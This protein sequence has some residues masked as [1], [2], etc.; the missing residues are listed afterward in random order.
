MARTIE[1]K[2]YSFEELS[3]EAKQV[4]I[5]KFRGDGIDISHC[6]DDAHESVKKFHEMFGSE[7][8]YRSWLDV[9]TGHIDDNILE[10]SGNRLRT[11]LINNFPSAFYERKYRKHGKNREEKPKYH[12]LI[13]KVNTTRDGKFYPVYRSNF[14]T[15]SSCPFTGA[16]YDEYLLF[17]FKEF[18]KAPDNRDFEDILNEA[19][20]SL[21]KSLED[22]QEYRDSDESIIEELSS[23]DCEYTEEGEEY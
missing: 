9:R 18:I 21:A 5:K 11:Y 13:A 22:E 7:E 1:V 2:L 15:E 3:E 19:V 8:G 4:A 23:N 10:L 16:C 6:Y 14:E 12:R 17:P 20:G